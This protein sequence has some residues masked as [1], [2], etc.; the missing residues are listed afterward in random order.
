MMKK[1]LPL[2]LVILGLVVG[3]SGGVFL[4]PDPEQSDSEPTRHEDVIAPTEFVKLN[5]QF[6]VPIVEK[7]RVASL[8]IMSLSI[9]VNAGTSERIFSQEPK[10][11]DAMLQAMFDHANAGGFDGVF[12]NGANLAALR[13]ALLEV[14]QK[15]MGGTVKDV[16]ISDLLRQDS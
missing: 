4:R 13:S 16:L 11:R 10:L 9:E 12:T 14:V 15:I 2:L 3:V 8:V 6:V 5:N 1:I 7:G